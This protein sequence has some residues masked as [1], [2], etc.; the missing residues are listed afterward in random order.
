M[1]YSRQITIGMRSTAWDDE[2]LRAVVDAQIETLADAI[3]A[4]GYDRDTLKVTMTAG[5]RYSGQSYETEITDPALNDR[6]QLDRQFDEAHKA[7]YG[8]STGEPWE[9][10]VLR[11]EVAAPEGHA[12]ARAPSIGSGTGPVRLGVRRIVF[13]NGDTG[14]VEILERSSLPVGQYF[15]G[16]LIIEDDWSTVILPP[17][18]RLKA[19][20]FG[21]L[22]MEVSL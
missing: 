1:S 14:D 17:G 13:E 3:V 18:D 9:L 7:L 8:Y 2:M 4:T 6:A 12:P 19:D 21:N 11:I 22:A 15:T 16:P 5:I 20:A 10:A